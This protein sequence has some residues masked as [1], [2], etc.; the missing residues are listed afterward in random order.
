MRLSLFGLHQYALVQSGMYSRIQG[1]HRV[2]RMSLKE[3]YCSRIDPAGTPRHFRPSRHGECSKKRSGI[4]RPFAYAAFILWMVLPM[5]VWG[6]SKISISAPTPVRGGIPFLVTVSVESL[7]GID[8]FGFELRYNENLLTFNG[9]TGAQRGALILGFDNFLFNKAATGTIRVGGYGA[10]ATQSANGILCQFPFTA[11]TGVNDIAVLDIRNAVDFPQA[12]AIEPFRLIIKQDP[13]SGS[14]LSVENAQGRRSSAV[15]DSIVWI[16]I[17][18]AFAAG[19]SVRGAHSQIIYNPSI[20]EYMDALKGDQVPSD[21]VI[22][23]DPVSSGT[24]N[25]DLSQGSVD[26]LAGNLWKV[27]FRITNNAALGPSSITLTPESCYFLLSDSS[28]IPVVNLRNGSVTVFPT[29]DANRDGS[30]TVADVLTVVLATL[31]SA[32]ADEFTD[33]NQDLL[34][35]NSD[36]ICTMNALFSRG[37]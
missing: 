21:Y 12:P 31:Y 18:A 4:C 9:T 32:Y 11:K 15:K 16:P 24:L 27:R 37:S 30:V 1:R 25:L 33:C 23:R 34:T 6:Q 29:G 20:L 26:L 14:G 13:L 22:T 19:N 17:D 8:A 35:N 28:Q 2:Q 3:F 36:I 7:A 5:T 10:N